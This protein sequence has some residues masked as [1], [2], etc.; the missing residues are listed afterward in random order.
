MEIVNSLQSLSAMIKE[1]EIAIDCNKLQN[2]N[3]P[4]VHIVKSRYHFQKKAPSTSWSVVLQ[5]RSYER[6]SR[7]SSSVRY[8]LF[9]DPL[10]YTILTGTEQITWC[11]KI[12]PSVPPNWINPSTCM[13]RRADANTN[14]DI[15]LGWV[16]NYWNFPS[17]LQIKSNK[18]P[19]IY[20]YFEHCVLQVLGT[21]ILG[22]FA[23]RKILLSFDFL[24]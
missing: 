22:C 11:D 2:N 4:C 12:L 19:S 14:G 24:A 1:K 20:S 13:Q 15:G 7:R 23:G 9:Y 5:C 16:P 17:A 21:R 18:H 8:C 6:G 3:Y 10:H